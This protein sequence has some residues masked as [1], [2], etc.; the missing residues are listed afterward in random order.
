MKKC[1][2][3]A[4]VPCSAAYSMR[5]TFLQSQG[6]LAV[7]KRKPYIAGLVA[8]KAVATDALKSWLRSSSLR[9][10]LY[11]M[12]FQVRYTACNFE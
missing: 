8:A 1:L 12:Q 6:S 4:R 7:S 10:L 11:K 9:G 3:V 5:G 2:N